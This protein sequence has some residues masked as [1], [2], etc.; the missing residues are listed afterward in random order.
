MNRIAA[1]T[2]IL[3]TAGVAF[4][5]ASGSASWNGADIAY[6]IA[7]KDAGVSVDSSD[8]RFILESTSNGDKH[9]IVISKGKIE[10]NG[11]AQDVA[12]YKMLDIAI[13]GKS[14]ILK[15]DGKT[16]FPVKKSTEK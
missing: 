4:A 9:K 6:K 7:G 13:D 11:A 14:L 16:I 3:L 1:M 8:Q 15:A 12:A 2:I 5:D 10:W